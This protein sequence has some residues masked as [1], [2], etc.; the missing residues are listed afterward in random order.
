V[1]TPPV[2]APA[3]VRPPLHVR[4]GVSDVH[5]TVRLVL[6][7]V[8]FWLTSLPGTYLSAW[9]WLAM[10]LAVAWRAPWLKVPSARSAPLLFAELAGCTAAILT[11]GGGGSPLLP[12]LL[13][14]LFSLGVMHGNRAVALGAAAAEVALIG[15]TI[16]AVDAWTDDGKVLTQWAALG[17]AAGMLGAWARRLKEEAAHPHRTDYRAARSLLR[18]LH[19][20][21]K[22]L[23]GSLDPAAVA[24]ALIEDCRRRAPIGRAAVLTRYETE[25]LVPLSVWGSDRIPWPEHLDRPSPLWEAVSTGATVH[26]Q[27]SLVFIPLGSETRPTGVLVAETTNTVCW[28]PDEIADLEAVVAQHE[29]RLETALLFAG[30][31]HTATL[32][33]RERLAREMHN[34]V[35]QDLASFGFELDALRMTLRGCAPDLADEV[36]TLRGRL[37]QMIQEIRYSISDLR[38]TVGPERGLGA[39]L[40][41]H[42]QTVGST[43][44]VA[45]HLS[46]RESP[47]RLPAEQEM[48]LFRIVQDFLTHAR[49]HCGAHNMWAS[50]GTDPPKAALELAHDGT[51][52]SKHDCDHVSRLHEHVRHLDAHVDWTARPGGG[53]RTRI[54]LTR[55]PS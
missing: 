21:S 9:L 43:G 40:S 48:N 46:L 47:L 27:P 51:V 38:T 41:T 34:G 30:L 54:Q 1:T 19:D 53:E 16:L 42:L 3:R 18:Q 4:L 14:P 35:A 20:L 6:G 26:R 39:A 22:R 15:V 7:G 36:L 33:E 10:L 11:T 25:E 37:T 12:Y 31:R 2:A 45:V 5:R 50:L 28:Q 29:L 55:G 23:P 17:L 32:E 49:K 44:G 8:C 24:G 52:D 13:A